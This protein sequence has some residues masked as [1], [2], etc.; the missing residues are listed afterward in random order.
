MTLK[1]LFSTIY[2]KDFGIFVSAVDE[3]V[4][5]CFAVACFRRLLLMLT[6]SPSP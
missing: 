5:A 2:P 4:V 3:L 6:A 1:Q